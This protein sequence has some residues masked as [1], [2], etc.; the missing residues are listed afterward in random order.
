M[1]CISSQNMTKDNKSNNNSNH[2]SI[3]IRPFDLKQK[4]DNGE[5]V[6]ILDVR[7]QEE[8]ES[9]KLTYNGHNDSLLLPIDTLSSC[10]SSNALSQIPQDKLIVT[11]CSHGN[12]SMLAANFLSQLGYD[13]KSMEGGLIG[14]NNVYDITSIPIGE[15]LSSIIRIWQ[16]R[17]VSK[18]CIGYLVSSEIDNNAILIDPTCEINEPLAKVLKDNNLHLTKVIDTHL[19]ADHI[20]GA[21]RLAKIYGAEVYI[22][23]LED[24]DT[25]Q[26]DDGLVFNQI[27]NDNNKVDIGKR[28]SLMAIH[29]P[30]HTNGSM[31]FRLVIDDIDNEG[32]YNIN[33]S[34]DNDNNDI[35]SRRT[36]EYLFTG[37]TIFVNGIGRPDLQ[38]KAKEFTYNLY[39]TY[40]QKILRLPKETIILPSHFSDSFEHEKPIY[41][42]LESINNRVK[43]LSASEEEF[44]GFVLG[45]IPSQ[46]PMNY[47]KIIGIN[48]STVACDEVEIED[49]EA[50]PNSC[51]IK[52]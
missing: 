11:L 4:I 5:D 36:T 39:N 47:D 21:S 7:T 45:S 26:N 34:S 24:Y 46:K 14:W 43:V 41:D 3:R 30:G 29:T 44:M 31:C 10:S 17:R 18:G 50:G 9:W 48:K 42:T 33:N 1:M 15:N 16:L 12:R 28:V 49:L 51:G 6:F 40:Q 25:K 37:D 38:D 23:S 22:S 8:Y 35:S 2:Q 27:A 32:K 52:T 13:A 20:S 19:H